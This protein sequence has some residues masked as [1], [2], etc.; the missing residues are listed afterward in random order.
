MPNIHDVV[1]KSKYPTAYWSEWGHIIRIH[2][3]LRE[4]SG[5]YHGPCP[6]CGGHEKKDAD[7]FW[8]KEENGE[9]KVFC[10]K[11][12]DFRDLVD[13]MREDGCWPKPE[14]VKTYIEK[15][16]KNPFPVVQGHPYL[17]NKKVPISNAKINGEILEIP[18]IDVSGKTI[19][20]QKI[21][22][23][24]GKKFTQGMKQA[25]AFSVV[26]GKLGERAFIT[27]GWA[28]AVTVHLAVGEAVIFG[29]NA[30]NVPK[31]IDAILE[32][33]PDLKIVIAADNDK[34]GMKAV[35][36]AREKH[37]VDF[38][39]PTG[40]HKDFN[41]LYLAEGLDA[42]VDALNRKPAEIVAE[43]VKAPVEQPQGNFVTDAKGRVVFNHHNVQEV[44]KTF[45]DWDGVFAFDEF[46]QR[47]MVMLPIPGT[48][49]NP[50]MFKPR[51]IRDS[52]YIDVLSWFNRNG[53]P[54][55]AKNTIIDCVDTVCMLGVIS[56]VKH[57]LESLKVED[58]DDDIL[59]DW[60][61]RYLDAQTE[62]HE[63]KEYVRQVTSKW[64][65]S[66]A[67]RAIDPGCKCDAVLI[68][69]G[70]QGAGK[71]TALRVLSGDDWFG[72]AL[73]P[74]HTK[75]ASDYVRG[76][77]IVELAEL[78]NVNKA[79][80]EI[81]K[82][83]VSRS[84]E[85]FRPAYGR[86]EITYPRQCVFAGTTNKS[87][88]LRDETGN[89]RFWPIKVG[90]KINTKKLREDRDQL[91]AHAV[92]AYKN[93][94]QW[95]LSGMAEEMARKEQDKRLA[96]DEWFGMVE[97]YCENKSDVSITEVATN[98]IGLEIKGISRA[99]QNRITAIF[100]TLGFYRNGKFSSG[101]KRNQARFSKGEEYAV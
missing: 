51:E 35:E 70:Y 72:D 10:R 28:D 13:R 32:K 49:G 96:V 91:W 17:E 92:M 12:C 23:K 78:S 53:F 66:A 3:N 56:P 54:S 42:V 39:I 4:I 77:W 87:D 69:E 41:E 88:Y 2:Y 59:E 73:P 80:V 68:L 47:K 43:Q 83:F 6:N 5:E 31:A 99:E 74:M 67:A 8:I 18:I 61:F 94:E 29:L 26:G 16:A 64:L 95:W 20:Y 38:R 75:D 101:D 65:I 36:Q 46:A 1:G 62:T 34:S 76:K 27:E 19:G 84:E 50:A 44:L 33:K 57:W 71:S 89:R 86:S 25:G 45:D 79:E 55:A 100:G 93:G 98:A 14:P 15:P 85:R 48:S 58:E 21:D 40:E 11:G 60:A 63:E 81:V 97:N 52:D 30:N 82:A 24:G 9:V 37:D 90:R 22:A 7:R